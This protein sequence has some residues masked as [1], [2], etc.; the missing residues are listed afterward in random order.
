MEVYSFNKPPMEWL[1]HPVD[2]RMVYTNLVIN[3]IIFAFWCTIWHSWSHI[4]LHS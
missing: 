2:H 4:L 1:I 3:H